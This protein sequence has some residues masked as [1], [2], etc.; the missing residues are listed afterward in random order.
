[1]KV[2][3]PDVLDVID[4]LGLDDDEALDHLSSLYDNMHATSQDYQPIKGIAELTKK[5]DLTLGRLAKALLD[6]RSKDPQEAFRLLSGKYAT[7]HLSKFDQHQLFKH[8]YGKVKD[9]DYEIDDKAQFVSQDSNS[10]INLITA[11]NT[12]DYENLK[13]EQYGL[14][15]KEEEDAA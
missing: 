3:N 10:L 2:A 11:F 14:K 6:R 4:E 1:M 15:K 7:H 8:A 9:S 12:K 13:L 5:K